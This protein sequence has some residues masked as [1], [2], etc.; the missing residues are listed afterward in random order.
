MDRVTF[1]G[2]H[3]RVQVH[4]TDPAALKDLITFFVSP[5]KITTKNGKLVLDWDGRGAIRAGEAAKSKL[6]TM[7]SHG[8]IA[9][10]S[11]E[12][13]LYAYTADD[14]LVPGITQS[15]NYVN[16]SY[17]EGDQTP[18]APG[19]KDGYGSADG[20]STSSGVKWNADYLTQ[21][22]EQSEAEKSAKKK[23]IT[24]ISIVAVA[25]IG[26]IVLAILKKKGKI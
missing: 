16:T 18:G 20:S 14:Y 5:K 9:Y 7:I 17:K 3:S 15:L 2:N 8:I 4:T 22:A 19:S 26:F 1:G 10:Y 23:K 12:N 6:E 24:I 21:L 25:I 13:P 11:P